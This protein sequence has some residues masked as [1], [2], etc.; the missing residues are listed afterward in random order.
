MSS[1]LKSPPEGLKPSECKKGKSVAR[2]PIPYVPPLDIIEKW[3][4]KQIKVKMPDG[5]NFGMAAFAYGTNK[6][7]LVH[8]IA[9]LRII[10]K[11]GLASDIKVAWDGIIKVRREM[12][13]YF[14]FPENETEA[15]KEIRKQTLSEYKEILKAK[16]V[17]AIAE[18]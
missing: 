2:P 1:N 10:E 3:E 16:K 17:F 14:L 4:A 6:D 13:P 12:K 18:I 5:T 9:V 11:K 8:I 7:Y 15:A